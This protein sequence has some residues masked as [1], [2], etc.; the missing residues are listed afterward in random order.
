MYTD[1]VVP[2]K[3][4]PTGT[5]LY[6]YWFHSTGA[7]WAAELHAQVEE[8]RELESQ[9]ESQSEAS[10]L[11]PRPERHDFLAE[12]HA[13]V[14]EER[15]LES[16]L[17]SQS[18]ASCLGTSWM[19]ARGRA[20]RC[21]KLRR[22]CGTRSTLGSDSAQICRRFAS[23]NGVRLYAYRDARLSSQALQTSSLASLDTPKHPF[24]IATCSTLLFGNASTS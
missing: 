12:L 19:V 15:E 24:P 20:R 1:K 3:A 16:Q 13:Q 9:L 21:G 11:G 2:R 5:P 22:R 4:M 17:E 23:V 8:E 7:L 10:C 6:Q 14:E 18:E